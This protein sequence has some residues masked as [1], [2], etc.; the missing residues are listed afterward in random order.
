MAIQMTPRIL[1][2]VGAL[3]L[4][5]CGVKINGKT[6]GAGGTGGAN[7]SA[8][9]G[10]SGG[11]SVATTTAGAA[12]DDTRGTHGGGDAPLYAPP[13]TRCLSLKSGEFLPYPETPVD[14]WIAVGG[15]RPI[16][17]DTWNAK[18]PAADCSAMH[19]HC[20]R[21]C[22][23]FEAGQEAHFLKPRLAGYD[24][25]YRNDQTM[26]DDDV[27]VIY[28]TVPATRRQLTPGVIVTAV[29][30]PNRTA[31][32]EGGGWRMGRLDRVD[33][34]SGKFYMVG[35]AQ[36]FW[37]SAARVAVLSYR[38]GGKVD[39][40]DGRKRAE[41]AVRP[42]E[43]FLPLEATAAVNDPWSQV[44][45][46]GQPLEVTDDRAFETTVADCSAKH[47]HCLRPWAWL[48]DITDGV[49]A[50]R[51]VGGEFVDGAGTPLKS[52]RLAYRT[53]PATR[54]T[55]KVGA[56]VFVYGHGGQSL[57]TEVDAHGDDWS[58]VTVKDIRTDGTFT[59][60][61]ESWTPKIEEAR[62]PVLFWFPGDK[63]EKVE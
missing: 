12:S 54:A 23:W 25:G 28:R 63:A 40:L 61:E 62:V 22:V 51:F 5:A 47:D 36:P 8:P 39:I 19:D 45:K 48:V 41:L 29:E 3:L 11:G 58:L 17:V 57:S 21:E 16:S 56:K 50:A 6:Y 33:H 44:G 59:V 53:A 46:D 2:A 55:L 35:E 31:T 37:L 15:E 14:P 24:L 1:V 18:R 49:S 34:K 27:P 10:G 30:Y 52:H 7:S 42:D 38:V 4:A 9:A 43:L 13:P 32:E 60:K 26:I 20:L